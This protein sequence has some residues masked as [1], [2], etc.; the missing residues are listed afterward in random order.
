VRV[1]VTLTNIAVVG[2][3]EMCGWLTCRLLTGVANVLISFMEFA[4]AFDTGP[5]IN[6][7]ARCTAVVTAVNY[8][9]RVKLIGIP[10]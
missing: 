10:S 7:L 6:S 8:D 3:A 1:S 5:P 9:T 4:R 2:S